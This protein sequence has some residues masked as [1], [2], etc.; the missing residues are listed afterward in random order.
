LLTTPLTLAQL[1]ALTGL[2]EGLRGFC[3]DSTTTTYAAA[4]TGGGSNNVPCYYD[5]AWKVG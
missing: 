1:N 5:G 3:T 2:T 4:I